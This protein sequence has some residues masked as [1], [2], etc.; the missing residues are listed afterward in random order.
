M[1]YT[2][3]TGFRF[4]KTIYGKDTPATLSFRLAN[5]MTVKIGD[6]VRLNTGGFLVRCETTEVPLGVMVGI[7]NQSGLNPFALGVNSA[8]ATL[9]PDDQVTSSSTNQTAAS[10]LQGEVV[11]DPAGECLWYNDSSSTLAQTNLL[12]FFDV[13]NGNQVTVGGDEANGQVQLIQI[14]PD[15]DGDASKGLFRINENQF[16]AG[17]DTATAK[18]AA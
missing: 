12:Q 13:A 7:V 2:A 5:S 4:R 15:G 14:D 3:S 1:A 16:S 10:Y 18:N 8:S 6:L 11:I 9:T 17:I